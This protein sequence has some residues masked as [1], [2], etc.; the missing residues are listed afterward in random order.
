MKIGQWARLMLAAAPL[1][2][3]CKGFWDAPTTTGTGTGTA[4]GVFFVANQKTSQIAGYSFAAATTAPTA[5]SG[6]PYTLGSAPLCMAISANGGFLYVST[7]GGILA[8]SVASTGALTAIGSGAISSDTPTSMV[9]DPNGYWLIESISGSGTLT[10]IPLVPTTGLVDTTAKLQSIELPNVQLTG[11]A[12]SPSG[13]TDPYVFVT[14]GTGGTA[15]IPFTYT[16][17]TSTPLGA[18]GTIKVKG[19][20][21]AAQAVAVDPTNRLLYVGETVAA[22][23]TQTGGLRVFTIG[24]SSAMTELTGASYPYTTGGTGPSA[25]LATTNYVYVANK[26]VSGSTT[27]NITGFAIT[28]TGSVYS[29]TAVS[30][31]GSGTG[32]VGLAEDS[33]GTYVLAVNASGSPDLNVYSFDTTTAGKLDSYATA[34]TGTDPVV[35]VAVAAVP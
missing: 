9:V 4:S 1:L 6:S 31:I 29:L 8:Y 25:I 34:A 3:G 21:G 19:T 5:I 7:G 20:Q 26:A 2:A 24:A 11:I 30:T 10:T 28:T 17:T 16:S 27:G 15:V 23:G 35:A 32:T 22:T 12:I 33:T 14:M 13:S 18:V